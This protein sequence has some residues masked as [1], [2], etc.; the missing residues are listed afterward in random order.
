MQVYKIPFS[1]VPQL[2]ARDKAYAAEHEGLRAFYKYPVSIEAFA[3][4]IKDKQA[5]PTDR[6]LLVNVLKEQYAQLSVEPAVQANIKQLAD[7][8]TFTL[9]TA[10]QPS[11]LTG[12]LYYIYKIISTI[13]LAK[14]LRDFYPDYHFVPVFI[15]GGEDHD[16]EEVQNA[17]LFNRTLTWEN[18]ETGSVGLMKTDS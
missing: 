10:H 11:L 18:T 13:N 16:F 15:T 8:Q 1:D 5:T 14:R 17:H 12:P 4:V 2:S 6:T 3:Q 7:A 9:T